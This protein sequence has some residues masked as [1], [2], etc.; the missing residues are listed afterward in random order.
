MTP[1]HHCLLSLLVALAAVLTPTI[2]CAQRVP[3]QTDNSNLSAGALLSGS[4]ATAPD[5]ERISPA[6]WARTESGQAECLRYWTAGLQPDA[7]RQVL[8]YIPSDQISG[9]QPASGYTSLNPA[10]LQQA[11][12]RIQS[13]LGVPVIL[14]TR[15][16]MLGSSGDHRQRRREPELRLM[17]AALDELKKRHGIEEFTLVGLSGGGH[18]VASLL[19]WRSDIVCAVP[20]SAVSAPRMRWEAKGMIADAT[21]FTD[22][23]EPIANLDASR[24]HPR[25]RVFVLGDPKDSNVFWSTQTPLADRLRQLGAAV[26]VLTGEGSDGE[27]HHL[28]GSG[29][30]IGGLC[31]QGRTTPDILKI[32]SEGLKG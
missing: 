23:Y 3:M 24:F 22:S 20:T 11:A 5:C 30:R 27:R 1:C 8:V 12:Q 9:S 2:A 31:L 17:S 15:P 7:N 18:V 21:G 25:L 4:S 28:G 26:E 29:Q 10:A 19:G 32:A 14:L 13:R 6:V 16:G